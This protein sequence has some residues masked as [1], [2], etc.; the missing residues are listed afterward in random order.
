MEELIE[1]INK[2]QI[3]NAKRY[4][5]T[6]DKPFSE[7]VYEFA[8]IIGQMQSQIEIIKNELKNN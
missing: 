6:M 7:I 8:G 2:M 5:E 1:K 3:A 4:A